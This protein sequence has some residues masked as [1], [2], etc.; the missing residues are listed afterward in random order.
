MSA[1]TIPAKMHDAPWSINDPGASGTIHVGKHGYVN[2]V[3]T[4]AETRTLALPTK[5]NVSL[6]LHMMT[7]GGDITLTVAS[8]YNEVGSTTIVFSDVGQ[9]AEF[10]SFMTAG[11]V[12]FWRLTSNSNIGNNAMVVQGA[13]LTAQLT[14]ITIADLAGTPDYAMSALTTLSPYG[15]ATAAEMITLLYVIQNMQVRMAE[16]EARLEGAGIVAAN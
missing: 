13:S 6:R 1:N 3:S 15:F 7:D 12:F 10:V 11:G 2:L 8:A 9:F 5:A 16:V 14:S 4:G